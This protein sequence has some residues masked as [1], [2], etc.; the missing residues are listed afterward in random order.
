MI[1]YV[2]IPLGDDGTARCVRCASPPAPHFRPAE[3]VLAD[4][5]SVVREWH[6]APGPNISFGGAEPFA[7]PELPRLVTE[8]VS[9]GVQ[10]LGLTTDGAALCSAQNAA[11]CVDAGVRHADI[12]LLGATPSSHDSLTGVQGSFEAA[13]QGATCLMDAGTA[14]GKRVVVCGRTRICRHNVDEVTGIVLAFVESGISTVSLDLDPKVTFSH[15]R[16]LIEAAIETGIV[17]GVWVSVIGPTPEQ[18]GEYRMHAWAPVKIV[19]RPPWEE[20]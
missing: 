8:S 3:D 11:G 16:P 15:K 19:D 18:L 4:V 10:R 5:S 9:L 17:Y 1:R 2:E 12:A 13:R 6:D 7:H 14:A 20:M